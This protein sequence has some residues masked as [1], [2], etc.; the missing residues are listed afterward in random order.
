MPD[1][2]AKWNNL[3]NLLDTWIL[4]KVPYDNGGPS[5]AALGVTVTTTA[6]T[7]SM[8]DAEDE[9][10][11]YDYYWLGHDIT[12]R[13]PSAQSILSIPGY[14]NYGLTSVIATVSQVSEIPLGCIAASGPANSGS[15]SP[16][17]PG[18]R[19]Q[20]AAGVA[21]IGTAP[22]STVGSTSFSSS[23]SQSVSINAGCFG[24]TPTA[25]YSQTVT[26]S[27]SRSYSISDVTLYNNQSSTSA[28]YNF[29]IMPGSNQ[30]ITA[31]SP[32]VQHIFR[33]A[34]DGQGA[35][36]STRATASY[37]AFKLELKALLVIWCKD[38][39]HFFPATATRYIPVIQPPP[40]QTIQSTQNTVA[41]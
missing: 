20:P 26:A 2:I 38:G 1:P 24:D 34:D 17:R 22:L 36:S 21:C 25:G 40:P 29:I 14:V 8:P 13:Q 12:V 9:N 41:A 18:G 31:F 16:L 28:Q 32:Y 15:S 19:L 6:F 23:L 27:N 37:A 7:V 4:D 10:T 35:R 3:P 30:S 5:D 33:I 39:A 11:V